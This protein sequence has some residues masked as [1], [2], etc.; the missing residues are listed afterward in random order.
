MPKVPA[1]TLAWSPVIAAYELYQT[2][3][4]EELGIIPDSPEWF[5]WLDQVSSFVFSGKT[6]HYTA[7][8]QHARKPNSVVIAT[9]RPILQWAS[10]SPKSI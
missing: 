6:G 9:G 7:P 2:R 8:I 1:Y 4:R 5:A 10:S 3:D